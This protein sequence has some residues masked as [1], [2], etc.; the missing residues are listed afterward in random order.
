MPTIAPRGDDH[1]ASDPYGGQ[2]T[3]DQKESTTMAHINLSDNEIRI[4]LSVW[5][6]VFGLMGNRTIPR[7][8]VTD[9]A[10]EN[11]PLGATRGLRAPGLGVPGRVKIGTW[12]GKGRKMFVSIRRS[13][14]AVRI[15]ATGLDRDA[16]LVSV[17]DAEE[18]I[19]ALSS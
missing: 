14:P 13:T 17:P 7:S 6:K 8:A 5:E 18:V 4:E 19:D 16:F 12:R 9:V 3:P 2:Q 1:E 10:L 15:E 11:D